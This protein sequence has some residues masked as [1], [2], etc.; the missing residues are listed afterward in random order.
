VAGCRAVSP[1]RN[2]SNGTQKHVTIFG[3]PHAIRAPSWGRSAGRNSVRLGH[4]Q[5]RSTEPARQSGSSKGGVLPGPEQTN[6]DSS[7]FR[8][9]PLRPPLS[10][11]RYSRPHTPRWRENSG[12]GRRNCDGRLS[13][14]A[15][16][17]HIVGPAPGALTFWV[18]RHTPDCRRE[19]R[20]HKTPTRA[21]TRTR[22]Q[23]VAHM[24]SATACPHEIPA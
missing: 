24:A 10:L 5:R 1:A 20:C 6:S 14:L 12:G 8:E 16:W 13:T 17:W 7:S 11:S 23:P 22:H 15:S 4:R 19:P 18:G 2:R 3:V 21:V 9:E